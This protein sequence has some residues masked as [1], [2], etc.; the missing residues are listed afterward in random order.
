MRAFF[1]SE[2]SLIPL[3]I[4]PTSIKS[5]P[6]N[7]AWT[8]R[9]FA[10]FLLSMSPVIALIALLVWGQVRTGGIPGASLEYNEPGE[11][12]FGAKAAPE[13]SGLDLVSGGIVDN[14]AVRG[15][16]VMVDFWSSWCTA[17]LAEA[18]DL[19]LVY[20]E[21]KDLPV[22]FV[23]IAIWDEPGDIIRY[24]N[25]FNISYPNIID[26]QGSTAVLYG[27]RG[28]PEKFFLDSHGIILR[29]LTGPVAPERLREI[30]DSLLAS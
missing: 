13:F 10:L 1:Y 19:A 7:S 27:V 9:R 2:A 5:R 26:S 22:E 14:A 17:C 28:V 3:K 23:G 29:K 20:T 21:Y 18:A 30:I 25:R 12:S 11:E 16:I 15:K 24:I 6:V 4:M 8:R